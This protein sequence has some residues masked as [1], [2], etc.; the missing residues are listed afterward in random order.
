M[1]VIVTFLHYFL[2]YFVLSYLPV[3]FLWTGC[4]ISCLAFFIDYRI[5]P[6]TW[7]DCKGTNFFDFFS[8][9]CSSCLLAVMCL[10]KLF[11]LY[12]PLRT[13]SICTVAMARRVTFVVVLLLAGINSPRFFIYKT[14]YFNG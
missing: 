8:A 9:H 5:N 3:A 13:R 6:Y 1:I 14:F 4:F 7:L 12:F 10:E 11:A 2:L